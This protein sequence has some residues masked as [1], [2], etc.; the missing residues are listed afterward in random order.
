MGTLTQAQLLTEVG[1][2]FADRDD[3]TTARQIIALNLSQKRIARAHDWNELQALKAGAIAFVGTPATDKLW[4]IPIAVATLHRIHSFKIVDSASKANSRK[5]K[6]IPQRQW[7]QSIPET[8]AWDVDTP[9]FYTIW[10][11]KIEF[12]KIP[13]KAYNYEIR[14][15]I[16]P[17]AFTV[18]GTAALSTL[19]DK[20]DA[21]MAW[22][23]SW[24]FATLREMEEA[25][26]WF[27][28]GRDFVQTS[29]GQELEEYESEIRPPFESG[30]PSSASPP[31]YSDPFISGVGEF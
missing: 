20:D 11:E 9:T 5:L 27:A 22:A 26:R 19:D 24:L 31:Y 15:S 4:A 7:D 6:W 14:H 1:A 12:F 18:D 30:F 28:I 13:D 8:E 29:I 17:T 2:A 23:I 25:N 3:I 16:W 21:I 10:R